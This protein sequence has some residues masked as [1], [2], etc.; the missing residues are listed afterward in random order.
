MEFG[1]FAEN[2]ETALICS[3]EKSREFWLIACKI[4]SNERSYDEIIQKF[5]DNGTII[6]VRTEADDMNY[7]I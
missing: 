4:C 7:I 2:V 6:T 5:P 1:Y 3:S